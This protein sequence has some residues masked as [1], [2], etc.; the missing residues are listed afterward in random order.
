MPQ[1]A[2]EYNIVNWFANNEVTNSTK[3]VCLSVFSLSVQI[4]YLTGV[5]TPWFLVSLVQ[6]LFPSCPG[7]LWCIII[8][9]TESCFE[10]IAYSYMSTI[11]GNWHPPSLVYSSY[12]CDNH[13]RLVRMRQKEI[14]TRF[15]GEKHSYTHLFDRKVV[16]NE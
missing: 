15:R 14:L 4:V 7:S 1:R 13:T 5:R 9:L 2:P 6:F 8:F 16:Y 12:R 11:L 3:V 10:P